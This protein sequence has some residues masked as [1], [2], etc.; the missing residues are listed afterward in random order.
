MLELLY[1]S[2]VIFGFYFLF[3]FCSITFHPMKI[4]MVAFQLIL[5]FIL[6]SKHFYK[7][8]S[9]WKEKEYLAIHELPYYP[10]QSI[11]SKLEITKMN[12]ITYSLVKSEEFSNECLENLFFQ[13]SEDCP[14]TDIIFENIKNENYKDYNEIEINDTNYT[15]YNNSYIYYTNKNKKGKL[16][17]NEPGEKLLK[18]YNSEFNYETINT[19]KKREE[20]KLSNPIKE[21]KNYIKYYDF[22]ALAF[23]MLVSFYIFVESLDDYK[24][25]IFKII[26]VIL[27]AALF[28]L[29]LI[30]FM[31]FVKVKKFLFDNKNS[32]DYDDYL[33]HKYFNIDSFPIA[34]EINIFLFY[35]LYMIF[36]N[37]PALYCRGGRNYFKKYL[38][39]QCDSN[40]DFN[41]QLISFLL[42][43]PFL[44]TFIVFSVLDIINDLKIKKIYDNMIYNWKTSP[45]KSIS[46][47]LKEDYSF[48]KVRINGKIRHTFYKW[49]NN[50]YKIERLNNYNF[51]NIYNNENGKLCGKDSE[52]NNLYFPENIDCPINDIFFSEFNLDLENYTKVNLAYNHFLYYTNK[53]IDGRILIDIKA[54]SSEGLQL[55]LDKTNEICHLIEADDTCSKFYNFSSI[56]FYSIIDSWN[57]EEFFYEY[58]HKSKIT[59]NVYLY[60]INYL[61]IDS[62]LNNKRNNIKNFK[63]DMNIYIIFAFFKLSCFIIIFIFFLISIWIIFECEFKCSAIYSMIILFV[64]MIYYLIISIISYIININAIQK[65]MNN[66]NKDFQRNKAEFIWNIIIIAYGGIFLISYIIMIILSLYENRIGCLF[67]ERNNNQI[68]IEINNQIHNNSSNRNINQANNILQNNAQNI[69]VPNLDIND[70]HINIPD[71]DNHNNP[72]D[73]I[74]KNDSEEN[75]QKTNKIGNNNKH[76][77]TF[78]NKIRD[79]L[80]KEFDIVKTDDKLKK[81]KKKARCVLCYNDPPTVILAPCHHKCYC[82]ECYKK[83]KNKIKKKCPICKKN[84]IDFVD[85][86][87]DP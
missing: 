1:T 52:G 48:G 8:H 57:F 65:I 66:I 21:L 15:H 23:L 40:C 3:F 16:Y 77:N 63:R 29:Y 51:L 49:K 47:S 26:N 56:P 44:L 19:I 54:S 13:S 86:I 34:V 85:K 79:S 11:N 5:C 81:D 84:V 78:D 55:N 36:P 76:N 10:I 33:P 75:K 45:I 38:C 59:P 12:N 58:R 37:K 22:V 46:M 32:F 30:R 82:D 83:N 14:I 71:I 25:S 7:K 43:F 87:Y 72:R 62:T 18:I 69:N 35:I 60:S 39:E 28:V 74:F 64:I 20:W 4:S 73:Y 50:Y 68:N 61:G 9:L 17:G 24:C 70:I 80:M 6:F 27:H 42:V 67:R 31:K 53:K 41:K 2:L